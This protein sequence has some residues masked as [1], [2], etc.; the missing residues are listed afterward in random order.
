MAGTHAFKIANEF[1]G[2]G[3]TKPGGLF[4]SGNEGA[5]PFTDIDKLLASEGQRHVVETEFNWSTLGNK[6]AGI[7]NF[8]AKIAAAVS[9]SISPEDWTGYRDQILWA[10]GSG[11]FQTNLYP[12]GK[13]R[14]DS[15]EEHYEKTFGFGKNDLAAYQEHVRKTRFP[16]LKEFRDE[17]KPQATICFGSSYAAY[18]MLMLK[19]DAA[20]ATTVPEGAEKHLK[21]FDNEKVLIT[22]FFGQGQMS[23]ELVRELVAVL[24]R[25]NVCLDHT[26]VLKT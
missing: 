16:I 10:E 4:F 20:A 22:P 8:T 15:W 3:D 11:V 19:L 26:K 12:L 13:P 6:G 24:K 21:V 14:L 2:W 23:D 17:L 7:R 9:A 5:A 25:W 1:I 18:F